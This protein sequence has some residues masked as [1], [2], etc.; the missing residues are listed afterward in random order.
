[1]SVHGVSG[2]RGA[3]CAALVLVSTVLLAGCSGQTG[4]V[5]GSLSPTAAESAPSAAATVTDIILGATSTE[6]RDAAG[7]TVSTFDSFQPPAELVSALSTALGSAPTESPWGDDTR[8][9]TTYTWGDFALHD[10]DRVAGGETLNCPTSSFSA[11][12]DSVNGV[13]LSTVDGITVGD[14]AAELEARYPDTSWRSAP[15][16]DPQG[17]AVE[18]HISVGHVSLPPCED[19]NGNAD[20]TYAVLLDAPDPLG[21]VTGFWGPAVDSGA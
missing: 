12:T 18:L 10:Y 8:P 5:P 1:M 9:G 7:A 16:D 2:R 15:L 4:A 3:V 14:D 13:H 6:F 17:E 20:R 21:R 11:L 19:A